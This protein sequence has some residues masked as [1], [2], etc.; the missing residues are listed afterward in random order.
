MALEPRKKKSGPSPIGEMLRDFLQAHM[1]KSVGDE[2]KVFGA[3]PQAVGPEITRQ[4]RPKAY[5]NGILFVETRHPLW[6][7]ELSSK[8]HLILRKLNQALGQDAVKD[9]H[10][11]LARY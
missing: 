7:S 4:A 2:V 5:R 11:R 1:P 10:F 6:T 3:W 9:I 8:R